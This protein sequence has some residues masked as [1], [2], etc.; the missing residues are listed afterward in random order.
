MC[1]C[2]MRG[3]SRNGRAAHTHAERG[4]TSGSRLAANGNRKFVDS[5]LEESEVEPLVPLATEMYQKLPEVSSCEAAIWHGVLP[6]CA[7]A[8]YGLALR[9]RYSAPARFWNPATR[10]CLALA[11]SA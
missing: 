10:Y 7:A 1:S 8:F 9:R 6:L 5:P 3:G 4:G 11:A 2:F